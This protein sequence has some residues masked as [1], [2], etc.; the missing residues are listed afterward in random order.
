MVTQKKVSPAR[1][2]QALTGAKFGGLVEVC[3]A[4]HI[5]RTAAFQLAR[6]GLLETFLLGRRR[7][8]VVASVE[9]LPAHFGTL[10]AALKESSK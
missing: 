1:N 2:R 3:S 4:F 6:E 8:V 10:P 7:M 9:A 5:G